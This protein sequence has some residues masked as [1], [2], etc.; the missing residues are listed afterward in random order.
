MS[1]AVRVLVADDQHL[2]RESLAL[3]INSGEDLTVVAEAT[4]GEEAFAQAVAQRPDVVLMDIR[5]PGGDGIEATRRIS[6]E[7][8]LAGTRVLVLSM[9]ELDEYVYSA[10]RAGA[11]GFLLKDVRP[12]ELLDAVRRTHAGDSLFAPSI[13]TR[14]VEHYL[15]RPAPGPRCTTGLGHLTPRETDILLLV[16]RG[17]SNDEIAQDLVLSVKT[18][19]THIGNLLAKLRAR[20]R[21]QLV[22]AAYRGGLVVP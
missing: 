3:L 12:A 1:G 6:A 14:L 7:P 10:L 13:L 8:G 18:V 15:D 19:K 4:T 20:D 21:A 16:A 11:S 22:I 5:M 17:R 9:F 2:F